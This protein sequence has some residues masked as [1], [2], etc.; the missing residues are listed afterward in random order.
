MNPNIS[1]FRLLTAIGINSLISLMMLTMALFT[2]QYLNVNY[3]LFLIAD[4]SRHIIL[5]NIPHN[6]GVARARGNA[7]VEFPLL[8]YLEN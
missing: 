3:S 5:Y 8:K 7:R 1:K 4:V 2:L 6:K